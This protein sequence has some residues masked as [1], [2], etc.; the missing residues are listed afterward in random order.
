M[1]RRSGERR[2]F[3]TDRMLGTLTRY[4]RFMGYD[5]MSANS[6]SPGSSRED[7]LLLEIATRDDRL[8]LTRDRELARRGGAQA[9]YIASEEIMAQIRQVA[10]LGVIEPRIR[11]SRCS[12]CNTRLRPATVREIRE[13]RYAPRSARGKEFSWCPTCRKLYW[14][15][16][17]SDRLEKRLNEMRSSP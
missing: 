9:I 2:R 10:D 3:L 8:L 15:G 17:H 12:L 11:M 16:S 5:T 7:T 13:A 4:L 6:L 1:S 14:M